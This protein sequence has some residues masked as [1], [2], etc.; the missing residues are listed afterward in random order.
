MLIL[1]SAGIIV[2]VNAKDRPHADPNPTPPGSI[3]LPTDEIGANENAP[4]VV[5]TGACN[6]NN[7]CDDGKECTDDLCEKGECVY[8]NKPD[9]TSC[10]FDEG[11]CCKGVCQ[12]CCGSNTELCDT[13]G[14]LETPD[15]QLWACTDGLCTPQP[16]NENEHCTGEGFCVGKCNEFGD[17]VVEYCP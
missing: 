16:N 15:C 8:Q 5:D 9:T 10:D 7:P 11:V 17:C 14:T 6:K 4:G 3:D 12:E 2:A 1:L 13:L